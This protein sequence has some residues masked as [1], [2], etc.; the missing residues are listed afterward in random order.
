M[1]GKDEVGRMKDE[2][3]AALSINPQSE[4]RIPQSKPNPYLPTPLVGVEL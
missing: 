4:I 1:A 3:L 2:G